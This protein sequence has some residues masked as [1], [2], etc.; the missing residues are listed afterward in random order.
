MLVLVLVLTASFGVVEAG[1]GFVARSETLKADALHLAMDVSAIV[2]ALVASH[3]AGR[4]STSRFPFGLS[5]AEPLAA[6]VNGALV[7]LGTVAIARN[8]ILA[9]TGHEVD[10][11]GH[12]HGPRTGIMMGVAVGALV[13][14]GISALIL[15]RG[16][17]AHLHHGHAHGHGHDHGH[18]HDHDD[19]DHEHHDH[20]K[21]G[22]H[23]GHDH[24]DHHGHDHAKD[25]G[26]GGHDHHDHDHAKDAGHGG[27]DHGHGHDHAKDHHGHGHHA[28]HP[29]EHE[30][31]ALNLRGALLHVLGDALGGFAALVAGAAIHFGAP[32]AIDPIASLVIAVLLFVGSLRLMR[33]AAVVLLDAAPRH[34]ALDR[35][36][37]AALAVPGVGEVL[38]VHTWSLG[39]GKD[40]VALRLRGEGSDLGD[41]VG[42]VLEDRFDVEHVWVHVEG[43]PS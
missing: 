8:A 1:A 33:D 4:P 35:V 2:L 3:L 28:E 7:L 20:A 19:C 17:H 11:D 25:G 32:A 9:L 13:I 39:G 41:R 30:E 29:E 26:H 31:A 14:N 43:P 15:H 34:L 18:D 36:K 21:D 42:K 5:R 38:S 27:H 40:A 12:D 24:H 10:H 22:G 16:A 37:K 23:G 6:L